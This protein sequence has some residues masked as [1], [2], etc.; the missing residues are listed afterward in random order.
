R[1]ELVLPQLANL[2]VVVELV[3]D[4]EPGHLAPALAG[5]CGAWGAQGYRTGPS[6]RYAVGGSL[7]S[8]AG[9]ASPG[10]APLA[11]QKGGSPSATWPPLPQGHS[12]SSC[13][14]AGA[15]ERPAFSTEAV[16]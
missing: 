9:A 4:P 15:E 14:A 11:A 1:G 7:P 3:V 5:W 13:R 8:G 16:A 2:R 12:A 10:P 6:F